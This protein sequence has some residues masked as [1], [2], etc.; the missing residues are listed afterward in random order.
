MRANGRNCCCAVSLECCGGTSYVTLS[1]HTHSLIYIVSD[2]R[3]FFSD[4]L[5]LVLDFSSIFSCLTRSRV[6]HSIRYAYASV[7]Y[8]FIVSLTDSFSSLVPSHYYSIH[9]R[10]SSV[11]F[12]RVY[13]VI[14]LRPL[15]PTYCCCVAA[16]AQTL[17]LNN[18]PR[19][20][21]VHEEEWSVTGR[22]MRR[23]IVSE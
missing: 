4:F 10:V 9:P 21:A 22:L 19:L 8:L 17:L 15:S 3:L 1:Y 11:V 2:T 18:I 7:S 5:R 14:H 12:L 16:R 6:H 13:V 23:S 20:H